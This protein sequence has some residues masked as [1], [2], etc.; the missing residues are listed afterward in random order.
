MQPLNVS[1]IQGDTRW[2]DGAANRAYYGERIRALA[3][4]SDLIVLPETFSSGFSNEVA[5]AAE[6]LQGESLRWLQALAADIGAVITGSLVIEE[7]GRYFNRLIWAAP[8]EP[9]QHYDKRHLFRMARE[10]ERYE[11]GTARPIFELRGWRVLPQVCYDLRFP[12][13]SRNRGNAQ[14]SA[15]MDYDLL[16][17]VANWPA[18]RRHAWRTLLRA[19]AIENLSY[20]IGVNRVGSDGNGLPYSGDSCVIDPLGEALVE[21]GATEQNATL[22]LDPAPLLAHRQRFPAWLDADA[23][24]LSPAAP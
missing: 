17:Y 15:G 13:W 20:V 5:V 24:T 7:Q 22:R 9:V 10:H 11:A 3:P 19:R 1:L 8:G 16:L 12:V 2:H 18:P 4:G 14:A 21:L 6:T 23:F